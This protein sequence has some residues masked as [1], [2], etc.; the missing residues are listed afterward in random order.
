MSK[1]HITKQETAK[2]YTGGDSSECSVDFDEVE[3][4]YIKSKV[5]TPRK[6]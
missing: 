4:N 3:G 2:K 6:I 5:K 1:V